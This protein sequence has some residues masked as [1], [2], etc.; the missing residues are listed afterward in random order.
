MTMLDPNLR[1]CISGKMGVWPKIT[2]QDGKFL[3]GKRQT[4]AI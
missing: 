2:L 4:H 3:R 1:S